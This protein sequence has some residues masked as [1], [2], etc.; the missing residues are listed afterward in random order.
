VRGGKC[1]KGAWFRSI[2]G[3]P[4]CSGDELRNGVLSNAEFGLGTVW[5]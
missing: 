2:C 1:S 5:C 3:C 4:I